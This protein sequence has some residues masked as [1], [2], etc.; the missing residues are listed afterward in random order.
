MTLDGN[1]LEGDSPVTGLRTW[2]LILCA[3]SG[4]RLVSGLG[5]GRL[6]VALR[7]DG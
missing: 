5:T 6:G 7:P 3:A 1:L 4:L 2:N